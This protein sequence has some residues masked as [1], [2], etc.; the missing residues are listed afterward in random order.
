PDPSAK[1]Y[2]VDISTSQ[3]F[4]P[5]I[6][7]QRVDG[8]SW[9][10]DVN[11]TLRANR[12]RLHWRVA[13]VDAYATVGSFASGTFGRARRAAKHK[14]KHAPQHRRGKHHKHKRHQR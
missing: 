13:A 11:Y 3:S 2:Q 8:A 1:Q 7:S 4:S 14:H 6:S 5:V 12:G 9:A 10:P